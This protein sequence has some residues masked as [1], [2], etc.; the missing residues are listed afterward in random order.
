MEIGN[1]SELRQVLQFCSRI[2]SDSTLVQ[3]A[4]GNISWK[5]GNILWIK[6]SEPD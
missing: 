1:S 6:A 2:G 3:G 5:D 4:G